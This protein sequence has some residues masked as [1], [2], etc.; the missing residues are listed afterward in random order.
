MAWV[1]LF[2]RAAKNVFSV[3]ETSWTVVQAS[4]TG[5]IFRLPRLGT[6]SHKV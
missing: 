4:H 3:N 2:W 6:L 5:C 1:T